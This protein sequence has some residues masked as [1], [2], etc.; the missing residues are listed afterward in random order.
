MSREPPCGLLNWDAAKL[1]SLKCPLFFP[2]LFKIF[3]LH[4][5]H[6][7]TNVTNLCSK[8]YLFRSPDNGT[9]ALWLW[10]DAKRQ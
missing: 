5:G 6:Q 7:C 4:H 10:P 2:L 9:L 3:I 1:R 8:K